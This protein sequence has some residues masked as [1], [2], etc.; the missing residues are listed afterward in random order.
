MAK[1]FDAIIE[2][3]ELAIRQKELVINTETGWYNFE[4][5]WLPDEIDA[6]R[7]STIQLLNGVLT[8]AGVDRVRGPGE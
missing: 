4:N 3:V 1:Q 8:E 5:P 6:G 2:R 7:H